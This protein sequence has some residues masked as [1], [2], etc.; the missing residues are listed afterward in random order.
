M[1]NLNERWSIKKH[2]SSWDLI[3]VVQGKDKDGNPKDVEKVRYYGTLYQA[4]QGYIDHSMPDDQDSFDLI[5]FH[6]H[7]VMNEIAEAKKQIKEEFC[8]VK[9]VDR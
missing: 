6:I 7:S 4:L 5:S 1:I 8:I 2:G 3:E 9:K